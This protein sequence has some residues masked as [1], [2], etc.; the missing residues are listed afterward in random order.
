MRLVTD[1]TRREI[2]ITFT[3]EELGE[4]VAAM[5]ITSPL[6]RTESAKDIGIPC[7]DESVASHHLFID[8]QAILKKE[9]V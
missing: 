2:I 5:G 9:A 8:L 4:L 6:D 1:E 3:E 7:M